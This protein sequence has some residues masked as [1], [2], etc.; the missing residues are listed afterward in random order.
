MN[1]EEKS[2][3]TLGENEPKTNP[4]KANRRPLAG[5]PKLEILNPPQDT[6]RWKQIRMNEIQRYYP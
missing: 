6:L 4:I 5:N 3:W 2:D 1:Y